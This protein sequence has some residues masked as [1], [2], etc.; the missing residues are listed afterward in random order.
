M[1]PAPVFPFALLLILSSIWFVSF[2][3]SPLIARRKGYAPYFWLFACGP[4]G[5]VV[6]A[7][8]PS[9]KKALTP[10]DLEA[11]QA[12]ANMTGAILTG[13]ALIVLLALLVPMVVIG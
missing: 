1:T 10:E 9:A 6:I 12:R 13:F 4:V 3:V 8:F 2:I 11:M 5:L 7:L